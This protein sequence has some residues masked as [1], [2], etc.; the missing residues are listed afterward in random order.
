MSFFSKF[1]GENRQGQNQPI[2]KTSKV[3]KQ[4]EALRKVPYLGSDFMTN[5]LIRIVSTRLVIG[6]LLTEFTHNIYFTTAYILAV[7]GVVNYL[8]YHYRDQFR[9]YGL[10]G[11]SPGVAEQIQT[12]NVATFNFITLPT[13]LEKSK[14]L[15][16]P[17]ET[18]P[19]QLTKFAITPFVDRVDVYPESLVVQFNESWAD[20]VG[21]N[22][23]INYPLPSTSNS[24]FDG[25]TLPQWAFAS[26]HPTQDLTVYTTCT[27]Q[28]ED[29]WSAIR[30]LVE[31]MDEF[32]TQ[33]EQSVA[34]ALSAELSPFY[35]SPVLQ[36]V[37]PWTTLRPESMQSATLGYHIAASPAVKALLGFQPTTAPFYPVLIGSAV[38]VPQTA[39][40][41]EFFQ[42]EVPRSLKKNPWAFFK[43]YGTL[44]RTRTTSF[45]D[46]QYRADAPV[47]DATMPLQSVRLRH[48]EGQRLLSGPPT[49]TL[50]APP[51]V[52]D[53]LVVRVERA[54]PKTGESR[55]EQLRD[56]FRFIGDT[57]KTLLQ[58]LGR[59]IFSA[60]KQY[61][62]PKHAA[63][64]V[65]KSAEPET[66]LE[67]FEREEA[68][69][70]R[71]EER[72][73]F[74]ASR[75][76]GFKA[77]I[78]SLRQHRAKM[79]AH[80]TRVKALQRRFDAKMRTYNMVL[81]RA[82]DV[83]LFWEQTL[84]ALI[85]QNLNVQVSLQETRPWFI[86][87]IT[88]TSQ[89]AWLRVVQV[90]DA[91][92][93]DL[94]V[95]AGTSGPSSLTDPDFAHFIKFAV[96]GSNSNDYFD[97]AS[98]SRRRQK[99]AAFL[100]YDKLH[101]PYPAELV[102]RLMDAE[103]NG[104]YAAFY[105][106]LAHYNLSAGS[107][108]SDSKRF[109][110]NAQP[111]AEHFRP[112][113]NWLAQVQAGEISVTTPFEMPKG[114]EYHWAHAMH[115]LLAEERGVQQFV[116]AL[117]QH[118]HELSDADSMHSTVLTKLYQEVHTY[119]D[120]IQRL[121]VP[122]AEVQDVH[123]K[124]YKYARLLSD[125]NAFIAC[126][127]DLDRILML[128]LDQGLVRDDT[129]ALSMF[130]PSTYPKMNGFV[131]PDYDFDALHKQWEAAT[132]RYHLA[133][134]TPWQNFKSMVQRRPVEIFIPAGYRP[135][136]EDVFSATQREEEQTV[137]ILPKYIFERQVA[138]YPAYE[139]LQ[140][141]YGD[142]D[143]SFLPEKPVPKGLMGNYIPEEHEYDDE[144]NPISLRKD[145]YFKFDRAL[146]RS[147][148]TGDVYPEP[149]M[150]KDV[151]RYFLSSANW[152]K[153][154][155]A[156]FRGQSARLLSD[157]TNRGKD[158][159]QIMVD[160][161]GARPDFMED[162]DLLDVGSHALDERKREFPLKL[163]GY[164]REF[165]YFNNLEELSPEE[166]DSLFEKYLQ[167]KELLDVNPGKIGRRFGWLMWFNTSR[168]LSQLDTED[169]AYLPRL[170]MNEWH[171]LFKTCLQTAKETNDPDFLLDIPPLLTQSVGI[172]Q[173]AGFD[174]T[175]YKSNSRS[176]ALTQVLMAI[177]EHNY[178]AYDFL[179]YDNIYNVLNYQDQ[180]Y[181]RFGH[182]PRLIP[183]FDM[184]KDE[185]QPE[186]TGAPTWME[187]SSW[188]IPSNGIGRWKSAESYILE[189]TG[190]KKKARD[191]S[192][193][194]QPI[195]T[196]L[197]KL[198]GGKNLTRRHV[199]HD[200]IEP[201]TPYWWCYGGKLVFYAWLYR[202]FWF[203]WGASWE[204][205]KLVLLDNFGGRRLRA[206]FVDLGI[207]NQFT[208]RVMV[209]NPHTFRESAG[210]L[211]P[212]LFVQACESVLHL[213]NKCR[214]GT[215]MP[216]G[217]LLTGIPGTGKTYMVQLI[218]GES[219]VPVI[220]QTAGELFN[221]RNFADLDM[222]QTFTPAEQ[223]SFAFERAR[224]LAPS[225]LFIDEIDAIGESREN[226]M[227]STLDVKARPETDLYG[228]LRVKHV[229][230]H[231]PLVPK[232]S[233]KERS[234]RQIFTKTTVEAFRKDRRKL[235]TYEQYPGAEPIRTGEIFVYKDEMAR[236][237]IQQVG[238]LTEF[239]VQMDGIQPLEGVLVIG[240]T[241]RVQVLDPAITRP[242][243]LEQI[244]ELFPPGARERL[245]VFQK[246]CSRVGTVSGI[247]WNYLVNRTRG[248]TVANLTA[249]INH[250]AIRAINLNSPHTLE[251]LEYGL[252]TMTRHK[253]AVKMIS[254]RPMPDPAHVQS[255]DAYL[256]LRVAYYNA[257]KALLQ[258]VL[259]DHPS[260]PFVKLAVEPFEP[261]YSI[262]DLFLHN[263]NR[264]E[265]EVRLIGLHA[266]KAAEYLMLYGRKPEGL[267]PT[268][269]HLLES[270]QGADELAF[271]AE[272]AN[273]MVD[274]WFLYEEKRLP[275][276]IL[277]IRTNDNVRNY[278][279]P[280][281]IESRE[282]MDYWLNKH[283][284][285]FARLASERDLPPIDAKTKSYPPGHTIYQRYEEF[286]Y[287]AT[288]V[289][290]IE[291]NAITK[292][293][294]QWYNYYLR[295]P[296]RHERSRFWIPPDLY[297]HEDPATLID[298]ETFMEFVEQSDTDWESIRKGWDE[299]VSEWDPTGEIL[300][301]SKRPMITFPDWHLVDR[302]YLM[303]S[304][305]GT[306]FETAINVL[307]EFRPLLDVMAKH[308]LDAKILRQDDIHEYILQYTEARIQ[309]GEP[310]PIDLATFSNVETL[311]GLKSNIPPENVD[312]TQLPPLIAPIDYMRPEEEF[313]LT[314]ENQFLLYER[315]WG[316]AS[317][318]PRGKRVPLSYF[319]N[320]DILKS[321]PATESEEI[322]FEAE[323]D[324]VDFKDDAYLDPSLPPRDEQGDASPTE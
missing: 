193:I 219:G 46:A 169:D 220:T 6:R 246:E 122:T 148:I 50:P 13:V 111:S 311:P 84:P 143:I 315:P 276:T 200:N 318:K 300:P 69:K 216:K 270:D 171:T 282:A 278:S 267:L 194:T 67:I 135:F 182:K 70:R 223:L 103:A 36:V 4:S 65:V 207:E 110:F 312:A 136:M 37:R 14:L 273:A 293:Y 180:Q 255:R 316:P 215:F 56:D 297:F 45:Q 72:N 239:L 186:P 320:K 252:D 285:S 313:V 99:A 204:E 280:I 20:L 257:G 117:S 321:R 248:L 236:R 124:G 10:Y 121:D 165:F 88:Q 294:I 89:A 221:K 104:G 146:L 23:F 108:E 22:F 173:P 18:L 90:L 251:T 209:D 177:T 244:I 120:Q 62:R 217:L 259:P 32:P 303:Q 12:Q 8:R 105:D 218:A 197:R 189:A 2:V 31:V 238:A 212:E 5:C 151:I 60:K 232:P 1:F 174:A 214:P 118:N 40:I 116:D 27:P 138:Y 149:S 58:D 266:G 24:Q 178:G 201:I 152:L 64:Q 79:R 305:M 25:V 231:K 159:H 11:H 229:P 254:T 19:N 3:V 190:K 95:D 96:Y 17:E 183:H 59:S 68:A 187:S 284:K 114:N 292:D 92:R 191:W 133:N 213:R 243:R 222:D 210:A 172:S 319:N 97:Y 277:N 85:R 153:D 184:P 80:N 125:V 170:T 93:S 269:L 262:R 163:H 307:N 66:P 192:K 52:P 168:E 21:R 261:E 155:P 205:L 224:E 304:L 101:L 166:K 63:P 132:I 199:F 7:V 43:A 82:K 42:I 74:V 241:N 29:P 130:M 39:L 230:P 208:Y 295:Q 291:L 253:Q 247:S 140:K 290:R 126:S 113:L 271:A 150:V 127:D 196:L 179:G 274:E 15:I 112:I 288:V 299:Q 249:A 109:N 286:A 141:L 306:S 9:S 75:S 16:P 129:Q 81:S 28:T 154:R 235:L 71:V 142:I 203:M 298:F 35:N 264:T 198:P 263:Y 119:L 73:A 57:A 128:S 195:M 324:E 91:A 160:R 49:L 314:E 265:L 237:E 279:R 164:R 158:Q 98:Q 287:W 296:F 317:R 260:L 185:L 250:S 26:T 86:A 48:N 30:G 139:D 308:L 302:D 137:Q 51:A 225:I 41:H 310:T 176:K 322:P 131:F 78:A 107:I 242:G 202:M 115:R 44:S 55:W 77:Y 206:L 47:Y 156:N 309:A 289:S 211:N 38:D 34:P 256:F 227:T 283:S 147:P 272:L 123:T 157:S 181:A 301:E 144:L 228:Y 281:D 94:P 134:K 323:E 188:R 245:Q 100:P 33:I 234:M 258:N 76:E 240:A 162:S 145:Y 106:F 233:L 83:Q 53:N 161:M 167:H 102:Q 175:I 61:A 87:D 54:A 226:V 275:S 268:V